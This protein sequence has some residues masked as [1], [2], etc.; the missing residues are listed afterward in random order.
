ME[1]LIVSIFNT[2]SEAYQAFAD[3]KSYKQTDTTKV[4]QIALVKNENGHIAEKDRYD[5]EDSTTDAA[6]T[7]GLV[8]GFIG[9]L[10]GT[11]GVLFGYGV[12]SLYG[13]CC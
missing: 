10:G 3:L 1:S 2:E 6:L 8:G 11:I 5:F 7:G 9:L 4:A 13:L 12:G